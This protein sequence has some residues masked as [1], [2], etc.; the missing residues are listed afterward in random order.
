MERFRPELI[1]VSAGFDSRRGDPLGHFLLTDED[2]T[3]LTGILLE[4][5]DRYAGGR[6]VSALEGGYDLP[7]LA[8]SAAAHVLALT[9]A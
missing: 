1:L 2:F 3:E 8:S 4:L 7:G 9:A 5:A 6:L